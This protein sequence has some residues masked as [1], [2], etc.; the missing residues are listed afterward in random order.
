MSTF[1]M[2]NLVKKNKFSRDLKTND[3]ILTWPVHWIDASLGHCKP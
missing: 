2:Q 3:L 1:I